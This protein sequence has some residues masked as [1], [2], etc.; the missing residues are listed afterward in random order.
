MNPNYLKVKT[1]FRQSNKT[2]ATWEIIEEKINLI[3]YSI[4]K[5][6]EKDD[7]IIGVVIIEGDGLLKGFRKIFVK[8]DFLKFILIREDFGKKS[9]MEKFKEYF[10]EI[11]NES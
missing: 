10:K 1:K 6:F 4:H 3:S 7:Y 5:E 11:K 8:K 9:I 2:V